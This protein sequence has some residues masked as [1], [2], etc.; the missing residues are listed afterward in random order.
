MCVCACVCVCV[1]VRVCVR[2]CVCVC[3]CACVCVCVCGRGRGC[4]CV[5][6]WTW[7]RMRWSPPVRQAHAAVRCG[8]VIST[9]KA[10][11]LVFEY[12]GGGDLEAAALVRSLVRPDPARRPTAA[13]VC[14]AVTAASTS[15]MTV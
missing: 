3:V 10:V 2:V 7:V 1:C 11:V 5:W 15:A 9:D 12:A 8:Q 4:V 6:A 13:Q 14:R